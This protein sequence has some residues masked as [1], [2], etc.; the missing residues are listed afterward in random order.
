[1][2]PIIEIEPNTA[3]NWLSIGSIRLTETG[4]EN[5]YYINEFGM[6]F[7]SKNYPPTVLEE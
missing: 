2:K 7:Y 5:S 1:M 3:I 6:I 4:E